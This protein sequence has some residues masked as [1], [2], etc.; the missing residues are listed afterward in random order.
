MKSLVSRFLSVSSLGT[1]LTVLALGMP[2]IAQEVSSGQVSPAT[3]AAKPSPAV[4]SQ[5]YANYTG[6]I[7]QITSINQLRDVSPQS[8]S[9]EALKNLVEGYGCIVGYP[10]G[11][12]RGDRPLT[13]NEF[14]AGLNACLT[15]IEKRILEARGQTLNVSNP[16]M[17]DGG[18]ISTAETGVQPGDQLINV[19]NRA[20]YND[21]GRFY[22]ITNISGQA[23]KIFG[24]RTFPGSF[25]D[26]QIAN[27]SATFEAVYQ[28]A[29]NQQTTGQNIRTRDLANPF[30][31]SLLE[32]PSYL[33]RM[34][35]PQS[36]P[37]VPVSP[38]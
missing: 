30:N 36:V 8:W 19:F 12:Y 15:Q 31:T 23:N 34:G 22:D 3:A 13:R 38:Y 37:P 11:T 24:W 16:S 25:F 35:T 5:E 27:D 29:L 9:Y 7:N 2:A 4:L 14:A 10:D 33:M 18:M 6:M 28:D 26:N 20:F 1:V 17:I 21:T 32:N